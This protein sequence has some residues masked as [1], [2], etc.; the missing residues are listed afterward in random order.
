M[1]DSNFDSKIIGD[2]VAEYIERNKDWSNPKVQCWD[3]DKI[4]S[5]EVP[6][7]IKSTVRDSLTGNY[8]VICKEC[9]E[10]D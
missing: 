6:D 4:V 1:T 9:A 8:Y 2:R 3:C 5:N 10:N 7:D